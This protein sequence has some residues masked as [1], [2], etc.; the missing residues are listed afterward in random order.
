M[1]ARRVDDLCMN[2][3]L[4]LAPDDMTPGSK[5]HSTAM[6]VI[7]VVLVGVDFSAMRSSLRFF[8]LLCCC[9]G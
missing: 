5:V 7:A 2:C 4:S 8:Q 3:L 1:R 6:L 9:A